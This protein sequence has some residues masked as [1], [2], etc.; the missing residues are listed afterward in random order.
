MTRCIGI[1]LYPDFQL[2]DAAGPITAFEIAG[3]MAGD[4]YALTLLSRDGGSIRS[5]A[6][7]VLDT[8]GVR[9]A[10]PL[11][12]LIV[13]GGDGSRN[14]MHC[15]DLRAFLRARTND[16]R[17]LC[18]VCSGAFL[19]A[20]ASLLDGRRATTHWQRAEEFI[21][22]FPH[23]RVD[24]DAIHIQDGAVWTSAG[25]SA[26]IDL[27]LALI[28][29]DLGDALSRRVAQQMVVFHRRPGGQSQFSAL[30]EMGGGEGRFTEL[31]G[32][33][34]SHLH[35]RLTV[36]TLADRMAMS[37]RNFTRTFRL[38]VGMSPAKAVERLR[39]E[40]AR[41]R[42]EHSDTPIETIAANAGFHNPER[43]RRAFLRAFGQPPQAMRRNASAM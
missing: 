31:L 3:R 37:P 29:D 34:R 36:E 38:S 39:L 41:E 40:A 10:G 6:G 43:M 13:V 22:L 26:G 2:L 18:S 16:T 14:A 24:P 11:D 30:L 28:G 23:V 12:T 5:S 20:A 27:A 8:T 25:I 1:L 19:L 33:I 35:N 17:R 15:P 21:R 7:I 4:A 9:D 32:W 42:V